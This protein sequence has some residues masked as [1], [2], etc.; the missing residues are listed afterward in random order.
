MAT[1]DGPRRC[2]R[3]PRYEGPPLSAP[4]YRLIERYRA[5]PTTV[6]GI[7]RTARASWSLS[8]RPF[9]R[10]QASQCTMRADYRCSVNPAWR[11][12]CARKWGSSAGPCAPV[13]TEADIAAAGCGMLLKPTIA[14]I[15]RETQGPTMSHITEELL[16]RLPLEDIDRVTFYMR[17]EMC[18][19]RRNSLLK[20]SLLLDRHYRRSRR[21]SADLPGVPP[22]TRYP[23][24]GS[25]RYPD[26]CKAAS[27]TA[28]LIRVR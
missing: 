5:T 16:A 21:H 24:R 13:T 1:V 12:T 3:T 17:D 22:S 9:F 27:P 26:R 10:R 15:P 14:D 20:E 7:G 25:S 28:P 6:R 18:A 11:P 8:R 23:T 2:C 4:P 19:P